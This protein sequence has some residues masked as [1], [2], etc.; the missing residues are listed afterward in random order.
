MAGCSESP[1]HDQFMALAELWGFSP[2]TL[3]RMRD[4]I[5]D[6]ELARP[7]LGRYQRGDTSAVLK[8]ERAAE[9]LFGC[10]HALA[11][12]SGTSALEA[13]LA[14]CAIGPGDEVLVPA[15][16]FIATALAVVRVGA[17][18]V[19]CD[20]DESLGLAPEHLDAF[21]SRRTKAVIPVH[22]LGAPARLAD[23][24]AFA[25]RHGLAVVEDAAQAVGATYGGRQVG[26]IGDVGCMSLSSYKPLGAGE[27]GLVL[28]DSPQLFERARLYHDGSTG[29]RSPRYRV[30]RPGEP[31]FC[32]T[33]LRMSELEGAVNLVEL[34]RLR[35]STLR[36]RQVGSWLTAAFDSAGAKLRRLDTA[37]EDAGHFVCVIARDRPAALRG[38]AA[39]ER[40][41][42]SLLRYGDPYPRDAHHARYWEPVLSNALHHNHG[43]PTSAYFQRFRR[44]RAAVDSAQD[45]LDRAVIVSIS[46]DWGRDDCERIASA[47]V[48]AA[49]PGG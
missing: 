18:P 26:T 40:A 25:Q 49:P 47:V 11:V 21:L 30:P 39:A 24:T 4:L 6:D 34:R 14:A 10:D 17:T 19:V 43:S 22:M 36:R 2:T 46:E 44:A 16:T 28:T 20:I 29:W 1:W 5:A 37:A 3:A 35:S 7:L 48:D 8:L 15:F 41:G 33:N 38:A 23:I 42:A 9:E 13:A 27:G 32:G 45:L 12:H 31:V